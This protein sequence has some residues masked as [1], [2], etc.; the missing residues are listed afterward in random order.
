MRLA[1]I[2]KGADIRVPSR[3]G[4][5]AIKVDR[6]KGRMREVLGPD[7]AAAQARRGLRTRQ[8]IE[9]AEP[10][11]PTAGLQSLRA[12]SSVSAAWGRLMW[13]LGSRRRILPAS[14]DSNTDSDN[15]SD[16]DLNILRLL[17]VLRR[18]LPHLPPLKSK[19]RHALTR[20][21]SGSTGSRASRRASRLGYRLGY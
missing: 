11:R 5:G 1:G 14:T 19:W 15:D 18:R 16:T 17:Q 21:A 9:L 6:R 13:S 20:G 3:S 4:G 10:R 2:T 12:G 8:R 7:H